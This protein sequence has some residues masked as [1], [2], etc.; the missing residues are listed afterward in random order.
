MGDSTLG[1]RTVV[2][3]VGI[4]VKPFTIHENLLADCSPYFRKAFRGKWKESQ[5]REIA[6]DDVTVRTFDVV[7]KWVYSQKLCKPQS[8]RDEDKIEVRQELL[9]KEPSKPETPYTTRS[10]PFPEFKETVQGIGNDQT[11]LSE[12]YLCGTFQAIDHHQ[13][14]FWNW[15]DLLDVALFAHIYD[16]PHLYTDVIRQWIEQAKKTTNSRIHCNFATVLRAYEHFP[17]TSSMCRLI[18][19]TYAK[20]WEVQSQEDLDF[21][22]EQAPKAFVAEV[23]IAKADLYSPVEQFQLPSLSVIPCFVSDPCGFHDHVDEERD[24]SCVGLFNEDSH[25]NCCHG[26]GLASVSRPTVQDM[27][28]MGLYD[29]SDVDIDEDDSDDYVY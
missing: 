7:T 19:H 17:E 20:M 16:T 10:I 18:C 29:D 12:I 21:M 15:D 24:K 13:A 25:K 28:A 26:H 23:L 1:D 8:T 3:K 6:L 9:D 11:V 14:D 4:N 2:V 22:R 5:N 27:R